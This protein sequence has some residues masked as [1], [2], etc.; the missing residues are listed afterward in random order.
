MTRHTWSVPA[1]G[2]SAGHAGDASDASGDARPVQRGGKYFAEHL[3]FTVVVGALIGALFRS[4]F[5]L[6]L[7][8]F[9]FFA[10]DAFIEWALQKIGIRFVPDTLGPEFIN[11]FVFLTGA[12]VLV[13][14][15]GAPKWLA[16]WLPPGNASWIFIAGAALVYAVLQIS[17]VAVVRHM[18]PRAGI[19][20]A[21]NSQKWAILGLT[22]LAILAVIIIGS[23]VTD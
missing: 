17:S 20:I 4:W 11:A 7:G 3:I 1:V 14:H 16:P 21:P 8:A 18:L 12:A 13:A 2:A 15:W 9:F 6:A 19:V 22:G 23:M 10:D 5:P